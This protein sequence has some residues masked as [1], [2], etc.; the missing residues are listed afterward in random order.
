MKWIKT[1]NEAIVAVATVVSLLI[2]IIGFG[3]MIWQLRE[4]TRTL[5]ASNTYEIQ[6]DA[7]SLSNEI[8][9]KGH[10]E[11]LRNG[12]LASDM[13][14]SAETD[15]W[16]MFNFY[17]AVFRQVEAGGVTSTFGATFGEDFCFFLENEQILGLWSTFID[18]R[19]LSSS[20][21]RM[22][23]IWCGA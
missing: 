4:T 17:L 6:R 1:H 10:I 14:A 13:A 9:S 12:T 21:Q 20:H 3:F 2:S 18:Q 16:L 22:K 7:R 11:D 5:Q 23:E 15:A 19:R 8:R